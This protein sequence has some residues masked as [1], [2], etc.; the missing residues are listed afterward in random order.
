MSQL[1]DQIDGLIDSLGEFKP[2]SLVEW[3]VG[4]IANVLIEQA[5]KAAPESAVLQVIEPFE[6]RDDKSY[7]ATEHA[8]AVRAIM[9][10]VV[11]ALP[12]ESIG[13]A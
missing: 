3:R 7:I 13:I 4:Q 11:E 5:Q 10:Q 2:E 9:R 6:P 8:G 12:R 1:K